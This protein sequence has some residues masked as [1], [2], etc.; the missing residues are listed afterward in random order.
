[1]PSLY[2]NEA[3]M[4]QLG[5]AQAH[6]TSALGHE[7]WSRDL[8]DHMVCYA[9]CVPAAVYNNKR[10][11]RALRRWL[12]AVFAWQEI[13]A[14]PTWRPNSIL[15]EY[16]CSMYEADWFGS[17][18]RSINIGPH[19]YLE[20]EM[21]ESRGSHPGTP[22]PIDALWHTYCICENCYNDTMRVVE[23]AD[24]TELDFVK[25]KQNFRVE[26]MADATTA[27]WLR[28]HGKRITVAANYPNDWLWPEYE[29][30]QV[31]LKTSDSL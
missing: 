7:V 21:A 31:S 20:F 19:L 14:R 28:L 2:E 12:V 9:F 29:W 30:T 13:E 26:V 4:A 16:D 15:N 24:A 27:A 18:C 8:D 5:A 1:M 17:R 10:L 25:S 22:P 11:C 3:F 23:V 6:V